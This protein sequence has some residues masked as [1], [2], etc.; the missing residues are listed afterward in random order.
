MSNLQGAALRPALLLEQQRLNHMPL[1]VV[2]IE[3]KH[4]PVAFEIGGGNERHPLRAALDLLGELR[5]GK[6]VARQPSLDLRRGFLRGRLHVLPRE[7]AQSR[8][9]WWRGASPN[10]YAGACPARVLRFSIL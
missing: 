3:E 4:P 8:R 2:E 5:Q 10:I 6:G 9:C 1:A 7:V